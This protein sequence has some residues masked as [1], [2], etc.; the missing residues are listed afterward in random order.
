MESIQLMLQ[1]E[2]R[3]VWCADGDESEKRWKYVSQL[4]LRGRNTLV[5]RL[6]CWVIMWRWLNYVFVHLTY[7]RGELREWQYSIRP[8]VHLTVTSESSSGWLLVG[9]DYILWMP[10][11][12]KLY[13]EDLSLK[14]CISLKQK[15]G[16]VFFFDHFALFSSSPAGW[17]QY[18][19]RHLLSPTGS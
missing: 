18:V 12:F 1:K 5:T 14:G 8:T 16:D 4:C 7:E 3:R 17:V 11:A 6:L 10:E 19:A 13:F 15:S 9:K 2:E